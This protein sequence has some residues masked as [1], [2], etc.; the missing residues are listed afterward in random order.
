MS[1]DEFI[2]RV[3]WGI[4]ETKN[5]Q[6]QRGNIPVGKKIIIWLQ[7]HYPFQHPGISCHFY[8]SQGVNCGIAAAIHTLR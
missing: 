2:T 4:Q 7:V 8:S 6:T 1:F 5:D 3:E